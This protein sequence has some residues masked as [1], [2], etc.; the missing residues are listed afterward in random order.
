MP[1]SYAPGETG[2]FSCSMWLKTTDSDEFAFFGSIDTEAAEGNI[3]EQHAGSVS[4]LAPSSNFSFY[5]LIRDKDGN[6]DTQFLG[7][8]NST[9]PI[10]DDNWHHVVLTIKGT[11]VKI[12]IDGGDAA[13]CGNEQGVP[14]ATTTSNVAYT[15]GLPNKL[16]FG[17][18]G[19][20]D[21]H[22]NYW[23][24]GKKTQIAC[25]ERELTG[26]EVSTIYNDGVFN[27]DISSL[28]PIVWYKF[29]DAIGQTI[30]DSG[31]GNFPAEFINGRYVQDLP[32]DCV[33]IPS[34][35]I[36]ADPE[37]VIVPTDH[38]GVH[39]GTGD[40]DITFELDS[41]YIDIINYYCSSEL[42]V[43]SQWEVYAK[44]S[45][46][47]YAWMPLQKDSF[48]D[49]TGT[50]Q[51]KFRLKP[52][53]LSPTILPGDYDVSLIIYANLGDS[54]EGPSQIQKTINIQATVL[55]KPD[56]IEITYEDTDYIELHLTIGDGEQIEINWDAEAGT[57]T[58]IYQRTSHLGETITKNYDEVKTRTIIITGAVTSFGHWR[59]AG[60]N[61]KIIAVEIR[62]M[63]SLIGF[64]Y[65]FTGASNLT[66]ENLK[67]TEFDTS[68]VAGFHSAFQ[69][70]IGLTTLDLSTFD[71]SNVTNFTYMF[72]QC[73]ELTHIDMSG[74]D[75]SEAN[76]L[77][78]MFRNCK[79][80]ETLDVSHFVTDNVSDFGGM[81]QD[82]E[83]LQTLNVS[84]FNTENAT[85]LS[86]MFKS[87]I[88]LSELD[89]SNFKTP[90]CEN[91]SSMFAG[92]ENLETL[93]FNVNN[94]T[95]NEASQMK[96]MFAGCSLLSSLNVSNFNVEKVL[97]IS[98]MFAGCS[99]LS[100]LNV[101]SFNPKIATS[102]MAMFAQCT[103][104][105]SLDLSTFETSEATNMSLMFYLNSSLQT[106]TLSPTKFITQK[107][108]SFT[109]MFTGCSNIQDF[110][111]VNHFDYSSAITLH[112]MFQNCSAMNTINFN[113]WTTSENLKNIS[114]MFDGCSSLTS[115]TLPESFD[116]SNVT[117]FKLLFANCTALTTL[118]INFDTSSALEMNGMFHGCENLE[119]LNTVDNFKFDGMHERGWPGDTWLQYAHF[120]DMFKDCIKLTNN[121]VNFIDWCT[122]FMPFDGLHQAIGNFAKNSGL[123]ILPNWGFCGGPLPMVCDPH[124]VEINEP[125]ELIET[126]AGRIILWPNLP[127][128]MSIRFKLNELPE[129]GKDVVLF[130][131]I[132]TG[133]SKNKTVA[134]NETNVAS[135]HVSVASDKIQ[136]SNTKHTSWDIPFTA[137]TNTWHH[138]VWGIATSDTEHPDYDDNV[139]G[140][141]FAC[142]NGVFMGHSEGSIVH[143]DY[144]NDIYSCWG[145]S[146][147]S[148]SWYSTPPSQFKGAISEFATWNRQ[149]THGNVSAGE[150]PKKELAL[151]HQY[152]TNE[153]TPDLT[154]LQP[155]NWWRMGD[156]ENEGT[157]YDNL[158]KYEPVTIE[159]AENYY[160]G[161]QTADNSNYYNYYI[162]G[163]LLPPITSNDPRYYI[164]DGVEYT[165]VLKENTIRPMGLK[166]VYST[167]NGSTANSPT[168]FKAGDSFT[169]KAAANRVNSTFTTGG[170][171]KYAIMFRVMSIESDWVVD[172]FMRRMDYISNQTEPFS[173]THGNIGLTNTRIGFEGLNIPSCDEISL[174]V[175]SDTTTTDDPVLDSSKYAHSV[176]RTLEDHPVSGV[177]H[178]S[179]SPY[180]S[181]NSS[182]AFNGT[183]DYLSVQHHPDL[184]LGSDDF[185]IEAH[186]KFIGT[187]ATGNGSYVILSTG[188][189]S[190]SDVEKGLAF[191]IIDTGLQTL[192][193]TD[194]TTKQFFT[195]DVLLTENTWYHVALVRSNDT[196]AYY[197]NGVLSGTKTINGAIHAST[198]PVLIGVSR[199]TA[200]SE[201]KLF[202]QFYEGHI[203]DVRI[204]KKAVYTGNNAECAFPIP[205]N[206][207]TKCEYEL[208]LM[209]CNST[210][211]FNGTNT[212]IDTSLDI[213]NFTELTISAY[214][215][216]NSFGAFNVILSQW[217]YNRPDSPFTLE[218]VGNGSCSF[219]YNKNGQGNPNTPSVY[220]AVL[221]LG[222]LSTED[223]NH[224]CIT[225]DGSSVKGYLNGY[226]VDQHDDVTSIGTGSWQN[227]AII[228]ALHNTD[229]TQVT[230]GF[231]S[232]D[233]H[234]IAVWNTCLDSE[235]LNL[236]NKNPGAV[237]LTPLYPLRWWR[238]GDV[239]NNTTIHSK[240]IDL[241]TEPDNGI[242]HGGAKVS[243]DTWK[244]ES[245][246]ST[247]FNGTDSYVEANIINSNNM[248]QPFSISCW[249]KTPETIS[250]SDS[251]Q[252]FFGT[253]T[254]PG[255][256]KGSFEFRYLPPQP[257]DSSSQQGEGFEVFY[258]QN[259]SNVSPWDMLGVTHPYSVEENTWYNLVCTMKHESGE[260]KAQVYVNGELIDQAE[261]SG[262]VNPLP[263]SSGGTFDQMAYIGARSNSDSLLAL[264]GLLDEFSIFHYELTANQVADIYNGGV[265]NNIM[266]LNP[267][268]WWTM[269]DTPGEASHITG[270]TLIDQGSGATDVTMNNVMFSNETPSDE[271]NCDCNPVIHTKI[272]S[273]DLSDT[274]Q[275][276]EVEFDGPA[277]DPGCRVV[278]SNGTDL[279]NPVYVSS[280]E[281]V[282][283]VVDN[284]TKLQPIQQGLATITVSRAGDCT[285]LE[286]LTKTF[287]V[288]ASCTDGLCDPL[289]MSICVTADNDRFGGSPKTFHLYDA[290]TIEDIFNT[291]GPLVGNKSY[292][293]AFNNS[294]DTN[295]PR[296]RTL[297]NVDADNPDASNKYAYIASPTTPQMYIEILI[298]NQ[299]GQWY[300]YDE[301]MFSDKADIL[302]EAGYTNEDLGF[303]MSIA[304]G[305]DCSCCG[306]TQVTPGISIWVGSDMGYDTR[307]TSTYT[308]T[309]RPEPTYLNIVVEDSTYT[310]TVVDVESLS[311]GSWIA[312]ENGYT[313]LY[314]V[315]EFGNA[316]R[317]WCKN[318]IVEDSYSVSGNPSV[319]FT[320]TDGVVTM[321]WSNDAG[322]EETLLVYDSSVDC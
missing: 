272:V 56:K 66:S 314:Y 206:L 246:Y 6:F 265:P 299:Q 22:T 101:S 223:W 298:C 179:S 315:A 107:V 249:W 155:R 239:S 271:G 117:N 318:M 270:I 241:G 85:S 157:F 195:S 79:K 230:D 89:I 222:T 8:D 73:R 167:P 237:D 309:N 296:L 205:Q 102:L 236:L 177:I 65:A 115:I 148:D 217:N 83:S 54:I 297:S 204:S 235:Q 51:L 20:W 213:S 176:S 174:L 290:S 114:Y 100:S 2:E 262:Y 88:G 194:G 95:T 261:L 187:P 215:R 254:E 173:N 294:S 260:W 150:S 274:L 50:T 268:H 84:N 132:R 278:D 209:C 255:S 5:V 97:D 49:I 127:Y 143:L 252:C 68:N 284:G 136:I 131:M 231:W 280:D 191:R 55:P 74:W 170:S 301:G 273:S 125:E 128:T 153:L 52:F 59:S 36:S 70:C 201:N 77:N 310:G 35:E 182:F 275:N 121:T 305:E 47:D 158:S 46:S 144:S 141:W 87:C 242:I 225:W 106:L 38:G 181:N 286:S 156:G 130:H 91:F 140:K 16:D 259:V 165:F 311:S 86:N 210:L 99:S 304:E 281:S 245:R 76:Y 226:L 40:N 98:S 227:T 303:N 247:I 27:E 160:A 4:F 229:G 171:L 163:E 193:S 257:Q 138:L 211:N 218:T 316:I 295:Y 133:D 104:L 62:G 72:Y 33:I 251:A 317:A 216:A 185:T 267:N 207:Y 122:D 285:H 198:E 9:L 292:S 12:Y 192:Y 105:T 23:F 190:D 253:K 78:A 168:L 34:L 214:V 248:I 233:I 15:G 124:S 13:G 45:T 112:H 3:G 64:N 58:E 94:F 208:P 263:V 17:K 26:S 147:Y 57:Q 129:E 312:K 154:Y 32:E 67:I 61:S 159:I 283:S 116:T 24:T 166:I 120:S 42:S 175:Q 321:K 308:D 189:V 41:N 183:S 279:G 221:Q 238:L 244:Y 320:E 291:F 37:R 196:F 264:E 134:S 293:Q 80:L 300:I 60:S 184:D 1:S 287:T 256:G 142:I 14:F 44:T 277:F 200:D 82:C 11:S 43:I 307:Y 69:N 199:G 10:R 92:N 135:I 29:T 48:Q 164:H 111:F 149:L 178:D 113:S 169:I 110:S 212:Y 151:L 19:N 93:T 146:A 322:V 313:T 240:V 250:E 186:I 172:T 276:W 161:T 103:S 21:D 145:K 228:G 224:L 90:I 180:L 109:N 302:N 71:V 137:T 203:Q 118:N 31:S 28:N 243:H 126:H 39:T 219:Y 266:S 269:G 188:L 258:S 289:P 220:P 306:V 25:W 53:T 288:T 30:P 119:T 152:Q 234:E 123:T 7:G 139:A 96:Y 108:T 63:S 18:N 282:V 81:F 202:Y 197:V 75:T 319:T 162:N 232:G